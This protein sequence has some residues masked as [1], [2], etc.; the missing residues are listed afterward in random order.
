VATNRDFPRGASPL[1]AERDAPLMKSKSASRGLGLSPKSSPK[2][3]VGPVQT[4]VQDAL[5]GIVLSSR[6]TPDGESAGDSLL[7]AVMK[8]A[9]VELLS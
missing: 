7:L 2:N 1:S 5:I 8:L 9:R 6:N 4:T 3:G